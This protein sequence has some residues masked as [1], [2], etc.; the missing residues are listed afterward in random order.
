MFIVGNG[1]NTIIDNSKGGDGG[2]GGY[3]THSGYGHRIPGTA[4]VSGSGGHNTFK[5]GTGNNSVDLGLHGSD[6]VIVGPDANFD[7]A[8]FT[9]NTLLKNA[10]AGDMIGFSL[11]PTGLDV[12]SAAISETN[13]QDF[14][15]ALQTAVNGQPQS[16]I[17]GTF[18]GDTYIVETHT[19][20]L[21]AEDTAIVQIVGSHD[22]SLSGAYLQ[23]I[24]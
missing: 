15:R 24:S 23:M 4:G 9:P 1:N 10:S 14:I 20:V 18:N 17:W 8:Q 6:T 7:A 12:V 19:G 3:A 16:V 22:F 2:L 13:L 21:G 11:D 5:L